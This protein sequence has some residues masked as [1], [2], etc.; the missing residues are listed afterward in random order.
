[1]A[2]YLAS[3]YNKALQQ[4]GFSDNK[5]VYVNKIYMLKKETRSIQ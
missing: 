1:M 3:E 5:R 2:R 4:A